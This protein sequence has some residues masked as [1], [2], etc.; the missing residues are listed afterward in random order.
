ML[1]GHTMTSVPLL[2]ALLTCPLG[3]IARPMDDFDVWQDVWETA[4]RDWAQPIERCVWGGLQCDRLA[5]AF[6]TAYQEAIRCLFPGLPATTICAMAITEA[7]GNHPRDIQTCLVPIAR[8]YR[9]NGEKHF[10]TGGIQAE[11]LFV[12]ASIGVE[13][14]RNQIRMVQV[15][16]DAA[17]LTV[18][19]MPALPFIPEITHGT[20]LFKDVFV[21]SEQVMEGDG[22]TGMIKPFRTIEDLHVIGA[23]LG[24]LLGISRRFGWSAEIVEQVSLLIVAV[25]A[26][27]CQDPMSPATHIAAGGLFRQFDA[28]IAAV[29]PLLSGADAETARRW[30][31]DKPVLTV[32][33]RARKARLA[34][35]LRHYDI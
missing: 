16:R 32:A 1:H 5:W 7:G 34:A 24:H 31:R 13:E 22:Y 11:R 35:A 9:L 2:H 3:E 17:G 29:D 14:G 30:E 28:L 18:S 27:A 25:C 10:I 12:A 4:G 20:V 15:G 19:A 33:D 6:F 26:L 23:V 8:G 21:P